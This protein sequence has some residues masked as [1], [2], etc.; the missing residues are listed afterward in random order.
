MMEAGAPAL[1]LH[2]MRAGAPNDEV[3]RANGMR[4][5]IEIAQV[6]QQHP[7]SAVTI[8]QQHSSNHPRI[9]ASTS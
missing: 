6:S 7:Q 1:T 3:L 2:L 8:T 4:E 9:R 5:L